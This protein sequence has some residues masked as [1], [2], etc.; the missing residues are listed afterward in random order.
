VRFREAGLEGEF[1][2]GDL[3]EIAFIESF[4]G[5]FNWGGGFG[6]F[7][8]EENVEVLHRLARAVR[9][10]GRVLVDH[11]NREFVLRHMTP[12]R[13]HGPLTITN[14]W[15]ANRERLEVTWTLRQRGQQ[16]SYPMS[17]R[18]YTQA[19]LSKLFHRIGLKPEAACGSPA[20]D[21]PTRASHRLILLGRKTKV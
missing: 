19:Q 4:H 21:K 18:L 12:E 16:R 10:G 2:V 5:A 20:G 17:I 13:R 7:S 8:D 1:L 15:N 6:H 3:R 11:P 9:P 14:R